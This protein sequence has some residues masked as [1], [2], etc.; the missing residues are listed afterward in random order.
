MQDTPD[1]GKTLTVF[2]RANFMDRL[3]DDIDLARDLAALFLDDADEKMDVLS[4]AISEGDA[5]TIEKTAH[6]LKGA[7]ANV[8]AYALRH[9]A[10]RIEQAGRQNHPESA[11]QVYPQLESAMAVLSDVLHREILQ[12]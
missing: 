6:S 2:D 12:A 11:R 4:A 1:N 3:E 9:L 5:D 7:A 10:Y 8:S